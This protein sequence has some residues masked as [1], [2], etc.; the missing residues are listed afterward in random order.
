MNE[1][2]RMSGKILKSWRGV[3]SPFLP[4]LSD[5]VPESELKTWICRGRRRGH[6][7]GSGQRSEHI[8]PIRGA[9]DLV[10]LAV[11]VQ[12][13]PQPYERPVIR[14]AEGDV[15]ASPSQG[16][17]NAIRSVALRREIPFLAYEIPLRS[18]EYAE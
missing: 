8:T 18:V 16:V 6:D 13:F 1:I 5:I 3:D 4:G 14:I 10:F 11:I 17:G 9:F 7:S 15:R 12:S 2:A